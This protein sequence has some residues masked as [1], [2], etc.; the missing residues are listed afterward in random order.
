MAAKSLSTIEITKILFD[1]GCLQISPDRPFTYASGLKGPL[2]CDNRRL[3][4]FPK[5]REVIAQAFA[6]VWKQNEMGQSTVAGMATAGIAHAAF[7]A[8]I[9]QLPMVYIR[10]KPKSHGKGEQV[11]GA[12][13]PGD[14]VVLAE[15][16][17]NQAASLEQGIDGARKAELIVKKALCIVDYQMDAAK[18]RLDKNDVELF[19]LVKFEDILNFGVESGKI[20]SLQRERVLVWKSSPETWMKA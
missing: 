15:D 12:Y 10:S 2:Y 17:V 8:N 1:C 6:E 5:Q 7:L 18:G 9:L 11:E 20:D 13:R 19:S 4:S 16:L 14:E 3:L